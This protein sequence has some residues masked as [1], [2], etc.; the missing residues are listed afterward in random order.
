MTT[1]SETLLAHRP[2]RSILCL[3]GDLP[4]AAFFAR[5]LP[6]IAADGAANRLYAAGLLPDLVI[7]DLDSI[8]DPV[9]DQCPLL[10]NKD[11]STTDFEKCL[12]YLQENH[13]LPALIVGTQ[14]G[15]LDH[16]LNNI[17]LF[18]A[19][20]SLLYAPP[21]VGF[22][23]SAGK[24]I[25]T[26]PA[27]TKISLL[28]FPEATLSTEGLRWELHQQRLT[29]PGKNSC[30]NRTVQDPVKIEVLAGR[31]LVLVYSEKIRDAGS[32]HPAPAN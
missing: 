21:L 7:G 15:S 24:E 30:F 5:D 26:L 6:L 27:D 13:L 11:Q 25:L 17:S 22:G 32:A 29:F 9:R 4:P 1:L 31:V 10:L 19:T 18:L 23:L 14:G 8:Q 2:V 3:N 20:D 28:G 16:T 12:D